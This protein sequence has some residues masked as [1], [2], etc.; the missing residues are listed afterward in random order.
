LRLRLGPLVELIDVHALIL[1]KKC[2]EGLAAPSSS[3][4]SLFGISFTLMILLV[5]LRSATA[6][7][8]QA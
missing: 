2:L 4:S 7:G 8:A 3:S 6:M 5:V 1:L